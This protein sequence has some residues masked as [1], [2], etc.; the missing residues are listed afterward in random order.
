M[1]DFVLYKTFPIF[2]QCPTFTFHQSG[3]E[4]KNNN[5]FL[6]EIKTK[7]GIFKV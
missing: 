3:N 5:F 6:R 7:M 4:I 2:L 1:C